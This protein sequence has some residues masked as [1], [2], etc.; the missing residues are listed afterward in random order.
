MLDV[1]Q[2]YAKGR[3]GLEPLVRLETFE[4]S[5]CCGC[6]DAIDHANLLQCL[7]DL[8]RGIRLQSEYKVESAG[9]GCDQINLSILFQL[10]NDLRGLFILDC[11]EYVGR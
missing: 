7:E 5:V 8:L 4:G 1:H 3:L 6:P 9:Y 10:F 2:G 11:R